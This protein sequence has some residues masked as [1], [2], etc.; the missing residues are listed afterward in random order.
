MR[1][2]PIR[3]LAIIVAPPLSCTFCFFFLG[4]PKREGVPGRWTNF[5]CVAKKGKDEA[6][7]PP[8]TPYHVS[9]TPAFSL[10]I[11]SP[12]SLTLFL[13]PP[14]SAPLWILLALLHSPSPSSSSSFVH[15]MEVVSDSD[16]F[17]L[18]NISDHL[19]GN[20][21]LCLPILVDGLFA[22]RCDSEETQTGSEFDIDDFLCEFTDFDGSSLGPQYSDTKSEAS[23]CSSVGT[24]SKPKLVEPKAE[25]FDVDLAYSSFDSPIS[26]LK[27]VPFRSHDVGVNPSPPRSNA[28]AK[29]RRPPPLSLTGADSTVP[30][31][32]GNSMNVGV[33]EPTRH[34]RGVRRRPWGKFAAEIR[35][36]AKQG[37]RVWLGTFDTAEEAARAY[38]RAAFQMRGSRAILNFPLEAGSYVAPSEDHTA[39]R[40]RKSHENEGREVAEPMA[41]KRERREP[42]INDDSKA[43]AVQESG[44]LTPSIWPSTTDLNG[45]FSIPHLSPLSP[46]RL[47]GY[48]QLL[49][50]DVSFSAG[51]FGESHGF[52]SPV[53]EQ[54]I[55]LPS[56][57]P[58]ASVGVKR[59]GPPSLNLSQP[60][61][62]PEVS[63][64]RVDV[65]EP[66]RRYRGV[67]R[68]PWGK[69][70]AE[71]RDPARQGARV[72]LG[73]FDTAAEAARAYDRAAFEMRGRKAILNFPL[74]AGGGMVCRTDGAGTKRKQDKNDSREA[75]LPATKKGRHDV[76]ESY[77]PKAAVH[78]AAPLTPSIWSSLTDVKGVF[79][80]PPL[81][82][83]SPHPFLGHPQ[84]LV[85]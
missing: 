39:S 15:T 78:N 25:V 21:S 34:Y 33:K 57:A 77:E 81:S 62:A 16:R 29:R 69:F 68:R 63:G 75:E 2:D 48:P 19:L 74:E 83:L 46:H 59:R 10:T 66:S 56:A 20:S 1:S 51:C 42:I 24:T 79:S 35:D 67:R 43:A 11:Y 84:L 54:K 38:D 26:N 13:S 80:I 7:P 85:V 5:V 49:I 32:V 31:L 64:N 3:S 17:I 73:T 36:P 53:S 28:G 58:P 44:P 76:P 60:R 9:T 27:V 22:G 72:W 45:I 37:A 18:E 40:K 47:L 4:S 14:T 61:P 8:S 55:V 52:H 65:E 30:A 70:A 6:S 12:P 50:F 71:I 82:P 23:S 41:T